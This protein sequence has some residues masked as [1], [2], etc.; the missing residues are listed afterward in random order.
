ME[1]DVMVREY[2]VFQMIELGFESLL[3]GLICYIAVS[4]VNFSSFVSLSKKME[5]IITI[6]QLQSCN[7]YRFHFYKSAIIFQII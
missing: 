1:Y 5:V 4:L 3:I 6:L 2:D 7:I